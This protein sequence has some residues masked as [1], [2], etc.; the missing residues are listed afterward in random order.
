LIPRSAGS[1]DIYLPGEWEAAA[2]RTAEQ[3]GIV[4]IVI[5]G[6]AIVI[7]ALIEARRRRGPVPPSP[8][9][10]PEIVEGEPRVIRG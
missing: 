10:P 7:F 9:P 2:R 5:A 1:Q 3:L 8:P 4:T 6:L